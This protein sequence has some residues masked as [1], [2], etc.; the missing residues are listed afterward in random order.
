MESHL[1]NPTPRATDPAQSRDISGA[2][3]LVAQ[4]VARWDQMGY[5]PG[6]EGRKI[7]SDE[8]KPAPALSILSLG[9]A[10]EIWRAYE[11][12][13]RSVS[14]DWQYFFDQLNGTETAV[15]HREDRPV[16]TRPPLSTDVIHYSEQ[17]DICGRVLAMS[18]L[19]QR[20]DKLI[21]AYRVRGHLI[22]QVDPL[23]DPQIDI[24]ELDPETYKFVESDLD[25]L[26]S[27]D[28]LSRRRQ[29]SLREIIAKLKQTYCS[30]IGVQY[31][32]I[33]SAAKRQWLQ[34]KMEPAGN[35]IELDREQQ[36][37]ILS[38][39]TE[40]IEFE[41]FVQRKFVGAKSFS[42]EGAESLIPLLEMIIEKSSVHDIEH[43]VIGMPHRGR[44]NVLANIMGKHPRRIFDEFRDEP[45][46]NGESP[47]DVKYHLGHHRDWRT[48]DGKKIHLD[49]MFNPSHLEFVNPVAQ[50]VLR[51]E[52]DMIG[53]VNRDRSLLILIHGDASVVGEGIV[54]ETL[55]LSNLEG[56]GIGGTVH[57]IVNNQIGFTTGAEQGRSSR[58]ASD[59]ARMLPIPIFHVNG[60]NPK[61][62][63]Q[64]VDLGVDFRN[65]FR[66]DVVIDMYCYRRRGHNESDDPTFTQPLM[67]KKIK[68]RPT[69]QKSYQS[70]LLQLGQLTV[71]EAEQ[72]RANR[73]ADL[74]REYETAEAI[75]RESFPARPNA[76][77]PKWE[78]FRQHRPE[79][80]PPVDTAQPKALLQE[81]LEQ[82][83][84]TPKGFTAHKK[85]VK[86]LQA[87]QAMARGE[88]PLD[89]GAA[90]VLALATLARSGTRVRL[91]GQDSQRGTFSHRHGVLHDQVTGATYTSLAHL[92]PDQAP[93]ELINSPLSEGAVLGFDFGY[94][95]VNPDALVIW[96]AQFGDFANAA[97]VYI[98]QFISAGHSKWQLLSGLTLFLPHGLEGTGP[99]HASARL[100]R[101]LSLAADGNY[102]VV[103]PTTPAQLFH[104][105]RRQVL[106]PSRRPLIVLT[107]KSI[108]RLADSFSTLDELAEGRFAEILPDPQV[109]LEEAQ[110]VL[111]CSG[112]IY[113]DL[114]AH[115][116]EHGI[117]RVAIIRLE[118]LYPLSFAQLQAQ[119][120]PFGEGKP[121]VWVQE[122]PQNMGALSH[123]RL[124]FE[125]DIA[126]QWPFH[127]V[128]RAESA[129]PATGSAAIHRIEQRDILTRAFGPLT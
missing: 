74:E 103:N 19:Q 104:L 44:L 73:L 9:F 38:R 21:H 46:K 20:V 118:Q 70:H 84:A 1:R 85:I 86:F 18:D 75:D 122:E 124:R 42:L 55:N 127:T 108:L 92:A 121:V 71:D 51:A 49:L 22:A 57:V 48:R 126:K 95:T 8:P 80:D 97:Q 83:T 79:T 89:W 15:A 40:A 63:A 17:C 69:V 123:I 120:H 110:R 88:R 47:S 26:F 117:D 27:V 113:Y 111:L 105:L 96:E 30:A 52:Q 90:E 54:Q 109:N 76:F 4:T 61:A 116:Q 37:R 24:T 28:T 13:P 2:R 6:K 29:L 7:D 72:I 43:I 33:E 32:H 125:Q 3:I 14:P 66:S 35:D 62:V 65:E 114:L 115:R 129:S 91:S 53:D 67:Y 81:L 93:V 128:A 98:D 39:L 100:E 78:R 94:S 64:A 36:I 99:E 102:Q 60:E 101:F 87:R 50:G 56:Y 59:V 77:E 10:E 16:I 68:Q 12:D 82:L 34:Q 25:L 107:P 119:L 41:Q 106:A 58:Y 5:N 112:K 23:T 45:D 11:R 31:M